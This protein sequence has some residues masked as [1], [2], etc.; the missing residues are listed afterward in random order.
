MLWSM[1]STEITKLE[2][3]PIDFPLVRPFVIATGRQPEAHNVLVRVTLADGTTGLGEA[4]PVAHIGGETVHSTMAA[5]ERCVDVVV[6]HD[7]RGWRALALALTQ[8]EP[9]APAARCAVEVAVLDA[10][11][12]HHRIPL[13]AMWGGSTTELA[14]DITVVAGTLDEARER[15]TDF[16]QEGYRALKVKVGAAAGDPE[17][18]V[19]RMR[20][21]HE[22]APA[23]RIIADANGAYDV[24]S[25]SAFIE[26]LERA[27]V[28]LALF[29]QPLPRDDE[30][31]WDELGRRTSIL[32]CADESARDSRDV[33]S[34]A[35]R[36]FAGAINIKLMKCG[37]AESMAMWQVARAANLPLMIGG[38]VESIV[39]MSASA[40]LAAG[41]GGFEFVDL[42]TPPLITEHPFAGGYRQ[43]EDRLDLLA[44]AS[45]HG[46]TLAEENDPFT[47]RVV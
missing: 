44:V 35:N 21:I 32:L 41:L 3:V 31:G 34:L 24:A 29:E 7:C 13:W 45:G 33:W 25:A 2:A 14:T 37:V 20:A 43:T 23:A 26:G 22:A 1:R 30:A 6:G 28:P 8:I 12:R 11:A 46:V 42:D 38:M 39:A 36:G 18:D 5:L 40:A 47:R 15:A 19:E 4:A 16:V 17:P 10:L 27:G 9:D